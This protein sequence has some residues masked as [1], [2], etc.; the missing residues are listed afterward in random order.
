VQ[1]LTSRSLD[2]EAPGFT[3]VEQI[4]AVIAVGV[5][6]AHGDH[7]ERAGERRALRRHGQA[8]GAL[9]ELK[10]REIRRHGKRLSVKARNL[11]DTFKADVERAAVVLQRLGVEPAACG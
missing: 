9:V 5:E 3:A 6:A 8:F 11:L 4:G 7:D 10:G 2:A 1:S